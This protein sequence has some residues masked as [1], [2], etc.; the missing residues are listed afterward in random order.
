MLDIISFSKNYG[1]LA[2]ADK[3]PVAQIF[4]IIMHYEIWK[5]VLDVI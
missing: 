2:L 4:M 3:Q 1:T 5:M